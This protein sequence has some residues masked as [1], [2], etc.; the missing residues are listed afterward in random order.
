MSTPFVP[1]DFEVPLKF[2]TDHFRLEPI[3]PQH[4]SRDH[5]AWMSSIEH[6]RNT[7]GFPHGRSKWPSTM[8]V[9][10]NLADLN[11]HVE[12]FALRKGFTYSVLDGDEVIGSVYVYPAKKE[13]YDAQALSWVTA[14]RAEL[15]IILW[16]T[17]SNWLSK[18]WPFESVFYEPRCKTN[19]E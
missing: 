10:K 6:I 4:N 12:D 15:D 14:N 9:E 11:R 5:E 16:E 3:G 18:A 17:V 13:G 19:D 1:I 2:Q 7:P 8:S